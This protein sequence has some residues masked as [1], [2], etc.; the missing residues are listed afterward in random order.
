MHFGSISQA[1]SSTC[2]A[3]RKH[4][5]KHFGSNFKALCEH[6][7]GVGMARRRD[8]ETLPRH[9]LKALSQCDLQAAR[10]FSMRLA[11]RKGIFNATCNPQGHFQCDLQSTRAFS[12]RLAIRKGTFNAT[13]NPQ[14]HFQRDLQSAKAFQ[15]DL[16][17]ALVEGTSQ[18]LASPLEALWGH[19]RCHSQCDLQS[20]QQWHLQ[21]DL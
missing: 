7:E 1:F 5:C 10:A 12:M 6:F 16:Q 17:P 11:I 19:V 13:C 8:A 3:L 9:L 14:R 20:N 2:E 15:C 18:T 4:S 21:C